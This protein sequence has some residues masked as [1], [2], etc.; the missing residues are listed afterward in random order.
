MGKISNYLEMI[1]DIQNRTPQK[2]AVCTGSSALT[3]REL[4]LLVKEKQKKW[5]PSAKK[6]LY[7]IQKEHA[8][9]QLTEFLTCQGMGYVPVIL[10]KDTAS[11]H[12]DALVQKLSAETKIPEE[13]CMA[14]MT[15]GTSG[16]NKLLFRTF[17]SWYNYFPF[18]MK[19][20]ILHL[21]AA[22]LC[23]EVWLLQEI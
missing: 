2:E 4:F 1:E 12:R 15:S 13:A 16:E 14:V 17:E 5:K 6:Q 22:C 9:D 8:L 10:P 7:F 20:F 23:R 3:Y 21:K 18:R 19:S 11:D